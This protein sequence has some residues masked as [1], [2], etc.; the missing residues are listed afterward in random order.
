MSSGT[1]LRQ[2]NVTTGTKSLST[3]GFTPVVFN[4]LY[5]VNTHFEYPSD[6]PAILYQAAVTKQLFTAGKR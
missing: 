4:S 6:I 3:K 1:L 2:L 5:R